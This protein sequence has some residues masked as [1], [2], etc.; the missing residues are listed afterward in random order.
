MRRIKKAKNNERLLNVFLMTI[1]LI[2]ILAPMGASETRS[3]IKH[4]TQAVAAVAPTNARPVKQETTT[5]TDGARRALVKTEGIDRAGAQIG[6]R[7]EKFQTGVETYVG[8]WIDAEVFYGITW[9]KLL[10]CLLFVFVLMIIDRILSS[11][12]RRY[13]PA[14]DDEKISWRKYFGYALSKPLK[15]FLWVYGL[16]AAFSPVYIHFRTATGTNPVQEIAQRAADITAA[17][18]IVWFIFRLVDLI[19]VRLRRWATRTDNNLDD[20]MAPLIGKALR[21]FI[22]VIGGIVILQNLTGVEIGPLLASLGIGGLALA[23]AAK[24]SI[25][26][27]FGTLTIL[28]DKPFQVGQRIVIGGF[29]GVVETVGLRSTRIRL[30][31]G[32]LVTI[33]NE[34]VVNSGLEN[35]GL[36][37]HI[38]WMANITI[39]YDTPADK[40]EQAVDIIRR[41]LTD[42]EGLHPDFPPR[43]FFNGFNDWSLNITVIAWYHPP[44]YWQYQSWLQQTCLAIMRG[45]EAEGIEFAFP[46]RTMYLANDERRQLKME[47]LK[48]KEPG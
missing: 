14:S 38:R 32:N 34:K 36:R 40:V 2:L 5:E 29:D 23:L 45:F 20:M 7:I 37:P 12:L 46:T 18:A 25:A 6:E 28:F 27:M 15:L 30:L 44:D 13:Q 31:T 17:V 9:L 10:V 42:H 21:I 24:D 48:G 11:L 35:I 1:G 22:V 3:S 43:V 19:D 4:Q 33:P 16:Y 8:G 41:I 47:M 39:T 26:N